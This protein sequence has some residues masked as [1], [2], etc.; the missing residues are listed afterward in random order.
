MAEACAP[1][2]C[3]FN[4]I[5]PARYASTRLPGK[6]LLPVA[7]KSL[8]QHVYERALE[9]GA[10]DV[11]IATDDR[12][13][14]EAALAFGA[15]VHMTSASHRT[16]TERIAQVVSE[17][18]DG[19]DRIIVNVQGDE[20]L[21]A[22]ACIAQV[23]RL[24]ACEAGADVATLCE[25]L[26]EIRDLF[27]PNVVKVVCDDAGN[28]LYFSRAAIPWHRAQFAADSDVMPDDATYLRHAGIY[29]YRAGYLREFVRRGTGALERVEALEQLRTLQHGG[30]IV[31][32]QACEAIGPGVDTARDLER[33]CRLMESS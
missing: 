29:A 23:A 10:A 15:H 4:V 13:I 16:G 26:T 2:E 24:L 1:A 17:R 3:G 25:P 11:C 33:V 14:R 22:P 28:A 12:R 27:D 21:L 30:R 31:V 6:P 9:S 18:N 8:L 32:A 7:G 5:I 19:P 20:P